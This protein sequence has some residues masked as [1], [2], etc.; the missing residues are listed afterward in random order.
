VVG[1]DDIEDARYA[2]PSLTTISADKE[3]IARL[4][5]ARLFDR[6]KGDE[7]PPASAS[8][9]YRL[10]AMESTAVDSAP[11]TAGS[12]RRGRVKPQVVRKKSKD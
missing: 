2:F 11:L 9:A 7:A 3:S 1:F 12:G 5:V 8:V 4:A 10:V 6:M